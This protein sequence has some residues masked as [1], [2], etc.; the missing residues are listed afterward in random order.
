[1]GGGIALAAQEQGEFAEC[2]RDRDAYNS[3]APRVSPSATEAIARNVPKTL[4]K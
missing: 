3:S 1:M 4:K 2:V